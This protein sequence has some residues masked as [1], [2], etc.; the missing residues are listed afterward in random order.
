[1]CDR[2][3][4][5]TNISTRII[6]RIWS[7]PAVIAG[8]MLT[9][10]TPV[11][12][13]A[14]K[15]SG[16]LFQET[17]YFDRHEESLY[18]PQN[19]LLHLEDRSHLFA[20]DVHTRLHLASWLAL[21]SFVQASAQIDR[22]TQSSLF[23]REL[24]LKLSPARA[25]DL[26]LGRT[27]LKWGVG[28]AFNPTGVVEPRRIPSDPSD[29][30]RRFRGLDLAQADFYCATGT[31][32]VVYLNT[33][34]ANGR[35]QMANDHRLAVRLNTLVQ[36]FDVALI[37]FWE[38]RQTGSIGGTVTKVIGGA[39]EIH[40]EFLGRRGSATPQHLIATVDAPDTLFHFPPYAPLPEHRLYGKYL[41]G[42]QYTLGSGINLAFEY[43]HNDEGMRGDD[44]QRFLDYLL[45]A[46]RELSNPRWNGPA[47]NLAAANLMWAAGALSAT[48][49]TRDYLF[50]RAYFPEIFLR[51]IS[52][53]LMTLRNLD[54]G[55]TVIIPA[56]SIYLGHEIS[57][58]LRW[59]GFLGRRES[60]YGGSLYRS[61]TNI[62][63]SWK[64]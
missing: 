11:W 31:V 40:G 22:N 25:L 62:G 52:G 60:E 2:K 49:S 38:K 18:N 12:A 23:L 28:Y 44:W 29:R 57:A 54:D 8:V 46:N 53:E 39:L 41:A 64:F 37:G 13:Q 59:S 7:N 14:L 27:I 20:T 26:S 32:T 3:T 19:R 16:I 56:L 17:A 35:W 4:F 10:A 43:F 48:G 24:V 51:R 50:A 21:R 45:F 61:V 6:C 47:G 1:M 15:V 42:F 30:L 58:S 63:L 36:G 9:A 34:N 55:S 5:L 33:L